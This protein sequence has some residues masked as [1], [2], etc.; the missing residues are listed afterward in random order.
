MI[1]VTLALKFYARGM[2]AVSAV[3]IGMLVGYVLRLY[4]GHG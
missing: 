2:V 1:V 3:V 4:D